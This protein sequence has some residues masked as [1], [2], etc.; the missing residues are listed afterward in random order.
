VHFVTPC[1][2]DEADT[3]PVVATGYVPVM[4]R[5]YDQILADR[6][7][8]VEHV[9]YPLAVSLVDSGIIKLSADHTRAVYSNGSAVG[10]RGIIVNPYNLALPPG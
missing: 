7:L 3:G 5:D 4:N 6:V 10:R 8:P 2:K 1:D 9:T